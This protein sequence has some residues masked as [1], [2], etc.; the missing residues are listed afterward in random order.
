MEEQRISEEKTVP[1]N[2]L[3]IGKPAILVTTKAARSC[4]LVQVSIVHALAKN[5]NFRNTVFHHKDVNYFHNYN[6]KSNEYRSA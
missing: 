5:S 6:S 3:A 2:K 4:L 1:S